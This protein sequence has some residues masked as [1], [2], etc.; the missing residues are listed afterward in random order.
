MEAEDIAKMVVAANSL[1]A[2]ACVEEIVVRPLLGD[3]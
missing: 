3:L 2:S 1:S